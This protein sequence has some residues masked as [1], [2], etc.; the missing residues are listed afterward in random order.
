MLIDIIR[1]LKKSFAPHILM[2]AAASAVLLAANET[3][4]AVVV[5]HPLPRPYVSGWFGGPVWIA[6]PPPRLVVAPAL[7]PGW[8]WSAG[9]W[10]WTGSA[11]VW[12]DGAW[13]AERAGLTFIP[14]H[15]VHSHGGWQFVGGSWIR[16]PL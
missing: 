15:W 9:Y 2:L 7:R 4:A 8:I 3:H 1:H 10:N 5:V 6:P 14:A 12:I 13:L 11:Y 16:R